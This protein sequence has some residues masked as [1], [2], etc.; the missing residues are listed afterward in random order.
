MKYILSAVFFIFGIAM[1]GTMVHAQTMSPADIAVRMR[2]A[3]NQEIAQYDGVFDISDVKKIDNRWTFDVKSMKTGNT[4]YTVQVACK[5]E[6]R[7]NF[8]QFMACNG[9][10]KLDADLFIIMNAFNSDIWGAKMYTDSKTVCLAYDVR[11]GANPTDEQLEG[12]TSEFFQIY[13]KYV[14]AMRGSKNG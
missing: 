2:T 13:D 8:I 6:D 1:L 4:A 11:L 7:C 3:M 9:L 12:W 14:Q 5:L 10:D